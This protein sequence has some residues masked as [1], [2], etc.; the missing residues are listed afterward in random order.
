MKS[1]RICEGFEGNRKMGC[2]VQLL[3]YCNANAGF[4]SWKRTE[5]RQ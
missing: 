3:Y 4:V 2:G 1:R 5:E